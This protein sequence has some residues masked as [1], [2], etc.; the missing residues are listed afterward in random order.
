MRLPISTRLIK[1]SAAG[2]IWRKW[3]SVPINDRRL[4]ASQMN[5]KKIFAIQKWTSQG[6]NWVGAP[7]YFQD[8][9]DRL[10]RLIVW[11]CW[12]CTCWVLRTLPLFVKMSGSVGFVYALLSIFNWVYWIGSTLLNSFLMFYSKSFKALLFCYHYFQLL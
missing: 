8:K 5:H 11:V 9:Q 1:E 6:I 12:P 7:E 3:S 4:W 10:Q 2:I